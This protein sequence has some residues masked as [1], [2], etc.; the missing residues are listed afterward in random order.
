MTTLSAIV[1]VHNEEARL[2]RCLE[3][4][5]FADEIVVLLD[6]CTDGSEAIARKLADK[7]VAGDFPVEGARR[8]AANGLAKGE[9]FLEVDADEE[10]T[11]ELGREI[12][13]L[14]DRHPH[15]SYCRVPIDNYVGDRLVRHGW[16]CAFGV[17]SAPRLFRRGSKTWG[18]EKV[19]PGYRF[20]GAR[21]PTLRAA[22]AHR[23]DDDIPDM[24]ARFDRYTALKA[25]DLQE[26]PCDASLLRLGLKGVL[27]FFKCYVRGKGYREGDMGVLIALLAALY[28]LISALRARLQPRPEGAETDALPKIA[29]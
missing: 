27:R 6:R 1:C 13:A 22:L 28:P 7:V 9:W 21:G 3:R 8:N 14:I 23:V 24:L 18:P 15:A 29:A 5:R 10:A 19:H 20:I 4:L 17:T 11:P 2:A 25:A 12:R 26:G 16:G